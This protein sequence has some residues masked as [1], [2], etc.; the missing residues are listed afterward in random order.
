[1]RDDRLPYTE[2]SLLGDDDG[3]DLTD[4]EDSQ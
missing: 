1:M 4:W 2:P 3:D